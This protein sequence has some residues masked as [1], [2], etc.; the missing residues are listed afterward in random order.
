MD[1][2]IPWPDDHSQHYWDAASEGKLLI[3]RCQECGQAQFYPRRHC[4]HCL[5][6]DPDWVEASGAGTLFAFSEIGRAHV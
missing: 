2:R 1:L 3:Q 6:A 4:I 5:A